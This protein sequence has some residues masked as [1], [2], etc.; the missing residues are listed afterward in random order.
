MK[1]GGVQNPDLLV[2]RQV[3]VEAVAERQLAAA[4]FLPSINAGTSYNMHSGVLQQSNGNILSVNR[5]SIYVGAGSL[6]V[7][8]GTVQIPGVVLSGNTD[9]V[10]F[11]YL[12]ARQ[13]VRQRE[14][15]TLA[16]RNQVLLRVCQ[17]YCDLLLAEGRRAV[18][19]HISS[20]AEQVAHI[21][22][23]YART[24][25]G[26]PADADRAATEWAR[27]RANIRERK[28]KS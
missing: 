28:E 23:Q 16:V 18:A 25:Q 10:L 21:T 2:S 20:D 26:R 6:A 27:R 13:Y 7:A 3:V 14:F 11:R 12:E 24:G 9:E 17:A 22:A 1:L 4:Q 15:A 5:S 8:G 19:E